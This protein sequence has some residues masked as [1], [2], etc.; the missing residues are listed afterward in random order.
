[1]KKQECDNPLGNQVRSLTDLVDDQLDICFSHKALYPVMSMAEICNV[2]RIYITGCGDSIAAAGVMAGV[3]KGFSEAF[4]CEAVEPM[5]FS[6]FMKKEELGAGEP[7]SPLVIAISAGGGTARIREILQKSKKMGAF[8]IL[9]TNNRESVSAQEAKRVLCLDTPK[10]PEDFPG[11]RSYFAGIIGLI[12]LA[13]RM[14]HVRGVLPPLAS[15]ECK[16]AVSSYVHSFEGEM[17][18][19][20]AQMFELACAWKGFERFEFIGDGPE[21]Y[22]A[23]FAMEKFAEV[24]GTMGSYD[25]S[26]DWCH[27]GYHIKNPETVGTILF[28]DCHSEGYGRERETARAA[29][30]IGRPLLI[31]TNGSPSDFPREAHVCRIPDTPREYRWLMPLMDYAPGA[32]LAGYCA[33]LG[34]RKFFNEYDPIAHVYNGGNV[35]FNQEIMTMKSSVIEIHL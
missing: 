1:M 4:H 19:M 18:R 33:V 30:G 14:G 6:R 17:E 22:S 31:I 9:I 8:T 15:R 34:G 12:A 11:L 16:E 5:D 7:D 3:M 2:R 20:E 27:I 32:I 28:A 25:D 13:V 24:T 26:E 21:Q 23:L 35:F 10:M 29:C